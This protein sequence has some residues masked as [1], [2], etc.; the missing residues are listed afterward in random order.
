MGLAILSRVFVQFLSVSD[1][2]MNARIVSLVAFSDR[3]TVRAAS[4]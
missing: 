1:I 4:C 2:G 3:P